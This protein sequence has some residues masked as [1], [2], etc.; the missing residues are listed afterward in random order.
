[1]ESHTT[2]VNVSHFNPSQTCWLLD[3]PTPERWKTV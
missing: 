1:M 3:L 2:Q